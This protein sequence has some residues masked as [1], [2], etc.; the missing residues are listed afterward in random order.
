M[1]LIYFG[2]DIYN[3]QKRSLVR[4]FLVFFI[5]FLGTF[6]IRSYAAEPR[7]SFY[8]LQVEYR[9]WKYQDWED[10]AWEHLIE[11]EQCIEEAREITLLIPCPSDKEKAD[12]CLK[13]LMGSWVGGTP[14]TKLAAI[15]FAFLSEYIPA[16]INDWRR[17]TDLMHEAKYHYEMA[18]FYEQLMIEY[19]DESPF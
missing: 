5:A 10:K 18:E 16:C 2:A 3:G 9:E 19:Y 6:A 13:I 12:Y 4:Y 7:F 8:D 11:A 15:A 17:L 14:Q 1:A